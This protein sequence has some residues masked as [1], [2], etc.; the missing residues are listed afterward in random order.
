MPSLAGK[1][2]NGAQLLQQKVSFKMKLLYLNP[3][4][5]LI[6]TFAP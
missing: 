1:G 2:V 6:R 5:T 3:R 4:Y